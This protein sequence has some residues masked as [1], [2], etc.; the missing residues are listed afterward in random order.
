MK[1]LRRHTIQHWFADFIDALGDC[2]LVRAET[3]PL[4]ASPPSL[5]PLR[6]AN[7]NTRYH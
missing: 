4:P 5:W 2:Q 3:Q 7:A 1:K 6:T